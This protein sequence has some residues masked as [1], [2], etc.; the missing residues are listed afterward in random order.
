VVGAV[1]HAMRAAL[2]ASPVPEDLRAGLASVGARW[3]PDVVAGTLGGERAEELAGELRRAVVE[4]PEPLW[5]RIVA[6]CLGAAL[7][8]ASPSTRADDQVQAALGRLTLEVEQTLSAVRT[9]RDRSEI[10]VSHHVL[11]MDAALLGCRSLEELSA[12]MA[13]YL[14]RLN[15]SRCFVVLREPAGSSPDGSPRGRLAFAY[16]DGE[17]AVD[18]GDGSFPAEALLPAHLAGELERGVLTAQPLFADER[19]FG[20]MLHEQS[21]PDRHTG[22]A[23][24]LAVSRALE[25]MHRVRSAEERAAELERLVA[26]RTAQLEREV[27]SRRAAQDGLRRANEELRHALLLDGL[28]GLHN[29]PAFD[30]HLS[31]E[32]RQHRRTGEPLSVLMCDVDHFKLYNDTYGHLAGDECLRLVARTLR[33]AV[34]R[35]GD[36][37]ARFGGEEFAVVLAG[38]DAAGALVVATRVLEQVRAL[39]VAHAGRGEGGRVSLSIGVATTGAPGTDSPEALVG[40]ADGALY[41]AK[42]AGRDACAVAG[43]PVEV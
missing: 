34:D 40:A 24:R 28:T 26:E 9:E 13:P 39:A 43:E 7:G 12:Q 32:W 14:R 31:R 33:G 22:E 2:A 37:V 18:L 30:G 5:W 15:V 27:A 17:A 16:H 1:L 4:H 10:A 25:E 11:D 35:G 6:V 19:L 8:A 3:L 29:R 38:T 20:T 23:L 42:L 41:R 21:T 36:V